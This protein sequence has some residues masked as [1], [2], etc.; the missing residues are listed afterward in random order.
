MSTIKQITLPIL[1]MTCANCV[2]AVEKTLDQQNG[3]EKVLVNLSSER[4]FVSYDLEH[5]NL[6]DI[7]ATI[8]GAGYKV[9]TGN[10]NMT[11]AGLNDPANQRAIE[12][13]MAE[14][15]GI[16]ESHANIASERLSLIYIPTIISPTEIREIIIKAGFKIVSDSSLTDN[17]DAE[18]QAR[19]LA[20]KNQRHM[21]IFALIFTV[22]LFILHML[23]SFQL[24]PSAVMTAPWL[25]WLF[26]ALATP[27]QFVAGWSFYINGYKA[28]KNGAA[29]MDVLVAM[30]STTAY[31]YSILI[32]LGIFPGHGYFESA[33]VIITLVRMGKYLETRAKG[34]ASDAIRKLL[35]LRPETAVVLRNGVE[36]QIKVDEVAIDDLILV[37]PGEKMPVDGIVVDGDSYADE[38]MLTGESLPVAKKPGSQVYGATLN[39]HG[40][41][42]YRATKIGKDTVLS[43]IIKLVEDAQA[44][45]APIQSL[46][47]K[48]SAIF[49]PAVISIALLTFIIWYFFFTPPA[50]PELTQLSRAIMN[51]VA[52]LVIACPCAMGL[53]TPTAIMVG[54]GR[55]SEL[56]I[57]V[58]D[59]ESLEIAGTVDMVLL[60]KTGT[61]TRGEPHVTDIVIM[62]KSMNETQVLQIA[63]SA[64]AGSEHPLGDAIRIKAF[65]ADIETL[66]VERFRAI[67]G[68]GVRANVNGQT[69]LIGNQAFI[70]SYDISIHESSRQSLN[71]LQNEAK[72]VVIMSID[73]KASAMFAI[74]DTLKESSIKAIRDLHELGLKVVMLTGDNHATAQAI[75]TEAGIDK[76]YA[77]LLPADKT[78]R[79]KQLQADG[80]KV[81][82]VGDG[83][84]D[85]PA[86]SQADVGIAIGTGTDVAIA[87]AQIV[88]MSGD[89]MNVPL[90]IRLSR[91]VL[92]TIRQ[93]L[94]WAF[95]YN[96]ILIPLAAFGVMN[97]MLAALAMAFSSIFV[98]T[99]SLR[100]KKFR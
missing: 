32:M 34:N 64:E 22:P 31:I 71:Q 48:I 49:V 79:I 87:S 88:S 75:A 26:F 53:A 59:S 89:L 28:L 46:A 54:I 35:Y 47:D 80:H 21:L 41:L 13:R 73:G 55:G 60:D 78:D 74:M 86:L 4:A 97:P 50:N 36:T 69:V 44:S 68:K 19:K 2:A 9:A 98:V 37:R 3:I 43:Q 1:G 14:S 82:M 67:S 90:S 93:N 33:A 20:I 24:L 29:N 16:I 12:K 52:V 45:K 23:H 25:E 95:F 38:S 6:N 40:S 91:R 92:R 18:T 8:E 56:G 17:E 42:T 11:L 51:A 7:I 58:K 10:I 84:N 61:I 5:I 27:V 66:P 39:T 100:L 96:I 83:I 15:F 85:A 63:A 70:E 65:E 94:F 76:V 30:G 81:A 99:N 77:G 62:D 57:L 72:T